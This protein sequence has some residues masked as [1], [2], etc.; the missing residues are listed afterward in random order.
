ML[1]M[2]HSDGIEETFAPVFHGH[3]RHIV[4]GV[5]CSDQVVNHS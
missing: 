3:H 1:F 4:P 5:L 2:E